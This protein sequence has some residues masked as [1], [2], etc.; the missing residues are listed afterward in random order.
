MFFRAWIPRSAI[1]PW[2]A[3]SVTTNKFDNKK[4]KADKHYRAAVVEAVRLSIARGVDYSEKFGLMILEASRV[5]YFFMIPPCEK[6]T[7]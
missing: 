5:I 4:F 6:L 1:S 7:L 2:T 3:E